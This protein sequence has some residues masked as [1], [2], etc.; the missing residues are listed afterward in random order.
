MKKNVYYWYMWSYNNAGEGKTYVED[1]TF[2]HPFSEME[3]QRKHLPSITANITLHNWKE[4]TEVE[5]HHFYKS[6]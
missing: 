3:E 6:R 1:V 2:R 5:F 4:I